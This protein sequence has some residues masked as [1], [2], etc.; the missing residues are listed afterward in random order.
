MVLVVVMHK[1][2]AYEANV[3]SFRLLGLPAFALA[4]QV[5]AC[6][7]CSFAGC[8][9]LARVRSFTSLAMVVWQSPDWRHR[10]RG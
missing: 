6:S 7:I 8:A 5:G 4:F 2:K 3:S 10:A 1:C 9:F